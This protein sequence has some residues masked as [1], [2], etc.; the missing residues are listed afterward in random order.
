MAGWDGVPSARV[1]KRDGDAREA[2]AAFLLV[3]SRKVLSS[4]RGD[5]LWRLN[6]GDSS[7]GGPSVRLC[8]AAGL[9]AREKGEAGQGRN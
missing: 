2:D 4:C 5:F 1:S 6:A 3:R 8:K 7:F 9:V